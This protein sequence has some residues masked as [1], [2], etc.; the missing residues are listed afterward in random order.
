M[1]LNVSVEARGSCLNNAPRVPREQSKGDVMREYKFCITMENSIAYDYISEK[2]WDGLAAGC[3]PV[4]RGAPNAADHL[5]IP[6]AALLYDALGGTP[7]ALAAEIRRLAHDREAYDSR[8]VWRTA[9][10]AFLSPGYRRLVEDTRLEH[11][12][13]RLCKLVAAMRAHRARAY[14]RSTPVT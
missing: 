3:L 8:F 14:V 7:E 2:V 12:Q 1:A 13:C 9:P 10:L 6:E 4:Y 11:S 5:P